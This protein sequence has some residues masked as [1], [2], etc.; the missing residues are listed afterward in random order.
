MIANEDLG[1][2]EIAV[3]DIAVIAEASAYISALTVAAIIAS[4]AAALCLIAAVGALS[5]LTG[6]L[7]YSA[8]FAAVF[9]LGAA[10][11]AI[12]RG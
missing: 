12:L 7:I 4:T 1:A 3:I 8:I 10:A 6:I 9:C 11:G 2:P 5:S